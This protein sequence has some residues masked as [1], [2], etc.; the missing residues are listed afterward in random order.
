VNNSKKLKLVLKILIC[1]LIILAGIVGVYSKDGNMYSNILP[2][3]TLASDING[4]TIL[5]F[6]VDSSKNTIYYDKDGK[7]VDSSEVTEDNEG[8]YTKEEIPVN[9]EENLNLENYNNTIKVMEQRLNLLGVD[10]Y[11][12]DLDEK[13]G[14][15]LISVENDYIEDIENILPREGRVQLIDSNTEDVIIDYTDFKTL[16]STYASLTNEVRTY[17][18]FKLNDSGIEKIKN[19]EKYKTIQESNNDDKENDETTKTEESKLVLK[20]DDEEMAEIDYDD[21]LIEGKTLRITTARGLTSNANINSRLNQDIVVTSLAKIGKMPVVYNLTAEEFVKNDI[22]ELVNYIVI[23]LIIICSVISVIFIIKYKCNGLIAVLGFI[24]NISL[25]LI[26]IRLTKVQIS[27]NGFAGML[28]LICLNTILINNILKTIK[29]KDKTFSENIKSAY[30]KSLDAIVA[31]LIAFIVLAFSAMNIISSMGLLLFWGWL[32]I[33]LGNLIF[34]IPMLA[35][36]TK[37]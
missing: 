4:V 11:Q 27:F 16:E 9:Q 21:I 22:G 14:K 20:F 29:L 32:I 13:T 34:T 25:F 15:V 12:I 31:M 30:L 2:D 19:I 10:Q 3:Y 26:V 37:E 1:I 24:T 18:N 28:G 36:T 35:I 23:V 17:I 6:E 33:V 8:N 5:E 7:K